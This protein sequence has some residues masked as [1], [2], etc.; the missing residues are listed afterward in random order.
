MIE[1]KLKKIFYTKKHPPFLQEI[2]N[3]KNL[4]IA[5]INPTNQT[6]ALKNLNYNLLYIMLYLN[7]FNV[8]YLIF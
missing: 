5:N 3:L 7:Y 6:L 2:L 4:S 1:L 8:L